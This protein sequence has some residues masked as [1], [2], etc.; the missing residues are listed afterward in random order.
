MLR[1]LLEVVFPPRCAGCGT[2]RWP[3]CDAC[4]SSLVALEPPWCERCGAPAP[5]LRPRC[6]TC[7]PEEIERARA[8]FAYDGPA[9]S[10]IHRL[11]FGGWR[12]VAE[13]LGASMAA[14]APAGDAGA[15][16]GRTGTAATGGVEV[17]TWVPLSPRRLSERGFDQARALAEVVGSRLGLPV[18]RLLVRAAD[19][20]AQAR[21]SG[22]ERRA[23]MAGAFR[24]AGPSPTRV[25]LVDDVLTTGATAAACARVLLDAGARSVLLLTAARAL[26]PAERPHLRPGSGRYTRAG[27]ASGSVVARGNVLR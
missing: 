8:P 23:A 20:G 9:R 13:A 25:L 7:P 2:G 26:A 16:A 1:A 3:F 27:P 17:A 10:A 19:T 24:S 5:S 18:V 15:P 6:R 14:V 11:K 4:R 12:G 21:R 22:A